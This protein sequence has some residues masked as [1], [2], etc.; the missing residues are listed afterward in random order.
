MFAD[1]VDSTRFCNSLA[2]VTGKYGWR[3]QL[4]C[5]MGTHFHLLVDTLEPNSLQA[6][7][8]S[9]NWRYATWFNRRHS[10]SGHL[11]GRRYWC[12]RTTTA[13]HLLNA[14]RYI[15]RNPVAAGFCKEPEAWPWSG[16]AAAIGMPTPFTFVDASPLLS[17]FGEDMAEASA[18]FRQFVT[19]A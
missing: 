9:L 2:E 12:A 15:A 17:Y 8:K 10:R 19:A 6:P 13:G 18:G 14:A 5:L 11:V 4:F 3:V 16:Y 1:D 7:M